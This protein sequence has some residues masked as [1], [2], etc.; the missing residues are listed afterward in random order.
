M[1]V[2]NNVLTVLVIIAVAVS[3][4]STLTLLS[5]VPGVRP[6]PV[7]GLAQGWWNATA[8]ATIGAEA[9]IQLVVASVDF[10]TMS[11]SEQDDTTDNSPPPFKLNNNGSVDINVS[12]GVYGT[13]GLWVTRT[14]GDGNFSFNVSNATTG[15]V[16]LAARAVYVNMKN[17]TNGT[18]TDWVV[19]NLSYQPGN[20]DTIDINLNVTV[21]QDE[22]AGAKSCVVKFNASVG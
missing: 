5:A 21:P 7:T 8:S 9:N 15:S 4:A 1:E 16:Y 20:T 10:G 6:V 12:V 2:S 14:S 11:P 17:H 19:W 22:P 18:N 13:S 3:I